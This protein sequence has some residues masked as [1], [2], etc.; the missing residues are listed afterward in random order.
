MVIY[1][2]N[3][4]ILIRLKHPLGRLLTGPPEKTMSMLEEVIKNDPPYK[5]FAI[6]DVVATNMIKNGIKV[7]SIIIDF[8][9]KREPVERIPLDNFEVVNVKNPASVITSEAW[10]AVQNIMKNSN[11]TAIVVDGEEDLLTLPIIKFAPLN[12]IVVYGQPYVGIVVVK[13]TEKVKLETEHLMGK[14]I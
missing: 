10:V 5:L 13:I 8:K 12:S 7:D 2:A 1:Q 6:G 9:T 11:P 4:S 3:E 14:M